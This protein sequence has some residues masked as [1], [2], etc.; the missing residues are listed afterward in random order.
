MRLE[1]TA[2]KGLSNDLLLRFERPGES[3]AALLSVAIRERLM[4]L[5]GMPRHRA[6][7]AAEDEGMTASKVAID[8]HLRRLRSSTLPG[9]SSAGRSPSATGI[10]V[11]NHGHVAWQRAGDAADL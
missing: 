7:T 11:T 8:E 6:A 10:S 3:T 1:I 4:A 9:G 2:S 5:P